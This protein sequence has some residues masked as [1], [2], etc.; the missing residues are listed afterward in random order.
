MTRD[1]FWD[2][3]RATRRLDPEAH[4]E[5]LAK[6][7]SKL[8]IDQILDFVRLWDEFDA[9]AYRRD[10]WAAAYLINGGCSDDGFQ[11]FCWWLLLQG[12][13]VYEA[14]VA[15]PDTLAG[16]VD[17]DEE[18][19]AGVGPGMDAWFIATGTRKDEAGYDAY[20]RALQAHRPKRPP[21]PKLSPRWDFDNDD[22]VRKRFPRLAKMYLDQ[23]D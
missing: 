6:R 3:I 20:G 14:A 18:V 13:A 7:L 16:V 23:N 9:A 1:E 12:R 17:G 21:L 8:P 19:E 4:S 15:N 10:L 2:H 5:R 22:E 11:Y